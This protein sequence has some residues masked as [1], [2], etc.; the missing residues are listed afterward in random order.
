MPCP[1]SVYTEGLRRLNNS[2]RPASKIFFLRGLNLYRESMKDEALIVVMVGN[3]PHAEERCYLVR[4]VLT[5]KI[6]NEADMNFLVDRIQLR[7]LKEDFRT[8]EVEYQE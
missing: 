2:A 6:T 4:C 7:S 5:I 8:R 1:K 3:L